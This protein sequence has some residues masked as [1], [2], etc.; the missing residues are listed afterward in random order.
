MGVSRQRGMKK[1]RRK[2]EKELKKE[3]EQEESIQSW[4]FLAAH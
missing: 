1:K 4:P 2:L 3:L